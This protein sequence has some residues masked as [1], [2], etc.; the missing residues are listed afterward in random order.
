VQIN[1]HFAEAPLQCLGLGGY[2]PWLTLVATAPLVLMLLASIVG[3]WDALR[4]MALRAGPGSLPR[5][6]AFCSQCLRRALDTATRSLLIE[7]A[8]RTLFFEQLLSFV[9]FP[10][11][12]STAFEA[13]ECEEIDTSEYRLIADYNIRTAAAHE[14]TLQPASMH[15]GPSEFASHRCRVWHTRTHHHRSNRGFHDRAARAC[16][17]VV[18]LSAACLLATVG[19]CFTTA[20]PGTG[21]SSRPLRGSLVCMGV[22]GDGQE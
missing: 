8:Y 11:V 1:I 22:C 10:F 12:C 9:T 3:F 2:L 18:L 13:F 15:F 7:T 21:L 4:T 5:W 16:H 14:L 6:R 17:P 19:A 20:K